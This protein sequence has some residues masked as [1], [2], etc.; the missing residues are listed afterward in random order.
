MRNT[1][2]YETHLTNPLEDRYP[3]EPEVRCDECAEPH[4]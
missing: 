2:E 1:V 3:E 4:G